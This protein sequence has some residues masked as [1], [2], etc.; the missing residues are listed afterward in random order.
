MICNLCICFLYSIL[1]PIFPKFYWI[2]DNEFAICDIQR[3]GSIRL[4]VDILASGYIL[5]IT[6]RLL[7]FHPSE[8]HTAAGSSENTKMRISELPAA[9]INSSFPKKVS[10]KTTSTRS[11]YTTTSTQTTYSA[12]SPHDSP[13]APSA[14]IGRAH[15]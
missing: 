5:P 2:C 15:V 9:A 10:N 6:G 8:T 4:A 11:Q 3:P 13:C 12:R 14:E 1:I 7:D